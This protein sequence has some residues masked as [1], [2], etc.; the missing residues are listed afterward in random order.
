[1]IDTVFFFLVVAWNMLAMLPKELLLF[2]GI[3]GTRAYVSGD[4]SDKGLVEDTEGLSLT[5]L[6]GLEDWNAFYKKQYLYQGKKMPSS[7]YACTSRLS[8]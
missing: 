7:W 5:D 1:M 3:D 2:L 8:L 4:F 6:L